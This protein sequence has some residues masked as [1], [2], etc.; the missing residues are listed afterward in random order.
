MWDRT[1]GNAAAVSR[2]IKKD[3]KYL[4]GFVTVGAWS[5]GSNYGY[6]N[7]PAWYITIGI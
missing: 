1:S 7:F 2:P 3:M 4:T 5:G 6:V